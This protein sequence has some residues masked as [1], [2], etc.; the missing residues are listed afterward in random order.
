M[1]LLKRLIFLGLLPGCI[2]YGFGFWKGWE[3]RSSPQVQAILGVQSFPDQIKQF[4]NN[5]KR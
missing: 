4:F 3:V 2:W 1:K 5:D